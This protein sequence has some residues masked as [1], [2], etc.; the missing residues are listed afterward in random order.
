M[1]KDQRGAMPFKVAK[2]ILH[3]IWMALSMTSSI[4]N[5]M[6][7]YPNHYQTLL[8]LKPFIGMRKH[9]S[10]PTSSVLID[11]VHFKNAWPYFLGIFSFSTY[12]FTVVKL[13]KSNW[14]AIQFHELLVWPIQ[15]AMIIISQEGAHTRAFAHTKQRDSDVCKML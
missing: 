6:E 10:P 15:I 1:A 4:V 13:S 12:I 8:K 2:H 5:M 7:P 11:C 14:Q 3:H 9:R